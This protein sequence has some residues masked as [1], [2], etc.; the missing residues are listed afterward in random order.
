MPEELF[1]GGGGAD[2]GDAQ[3][4]QLR[5]ANR[6]GLIAGAT[7]TGKTVTLQIL[8]E[9]FSNQGVP[10]ILA[11][12]KGDLS[13]LTKAGSA[14][15]ELHDAFVKR[16]Q[17]IGFTAFDYH[18]VPVTF[19]DLFGQQGHPVRTTIAE[20][21][22]LLLGRLLE[23]SDAQEGI[24]NIAFRLA[25]EQGL[26][27][28][29]LKD[30]Q[31]LLVWVGENRDALSLRY[32]NVSTASIGAIQRRLLVLENQGGADMFGEP[33]LDLRD[34]MRRDDTGRGMVNIL[35][36]DKL[37]AAPKL[38]A[39]FLLWL[40]SELF[41]TL[42][43]VG[44]PDKPELVFF[45]D[46]AHL[47]FEDAPK[48]LVD[49]VEQV[50]RLIRSKGVGVYFVTQSPDD[51]PED[52]LGQLGNRIQH[53]LRAFTARDR[54]KLKLAAETYR[55]NPRFSTEDAIRDVGVG[56]A[57]TSLLEKKAVPGI[58]ER[59][60]IRPPSSQL[61]PITPAERA[62]VLRHSP[63]SGKYDAPVDRNSAYEILMARAS[64]AAT[65]AA[66]AEDQA[67]HAPDP[68]VREF[69][70]ARRY[71]GS[72]VGRSSARRIGG[73]DT[74]ASAMSEAVIKEL[75]GTTGRRIVRGIL[76]GLFKGR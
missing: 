10:V 30:L 13:G 7:G 70:A 32:G 51:I 69:N 42:P 48:A 45:F 41:E 37:M 6:H 22:P 71:S 8:A 14:S 67:E 56:E 44:D 58:V 46:E 2:Y 39:T 74:I 29:D 40:L 24:L 43:E 60:L 76:G 49:K 12:V 3:H 65:E 1:I 11:D 33:A 19:W 53:A 31:A 50:A 73:A 68:M 28:L 62:E 26:P 75:K 72:R 52:I 34:L 36:A 35:A 25:D 15:A 27:L 47:L 66:D 59:T 63:M 61:G 16:A 38:Y 9:S 55:E 23:L 54:K 4:L 64:T 57:V 21:G 20:M 17:K 5:Y 18:D